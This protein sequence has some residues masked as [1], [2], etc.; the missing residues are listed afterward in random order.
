MLI[1]VYEPGGLIE[2]WHRLAGDRLRR[3]AVQ[4]ALDHAA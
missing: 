4:R 1:S 3:R 2:M